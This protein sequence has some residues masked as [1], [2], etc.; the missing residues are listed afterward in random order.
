MLAKPDGIPWAILRTLG[1]PPLTRVHARGLLRVRGDQAHRA[2][3]L[4]WGRVETD[5]ERESVHQA[6]GVAEAIRR[7]SRTPPRTG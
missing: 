1:I 5:T 2:V 4:G 6:R 3:P 7:R